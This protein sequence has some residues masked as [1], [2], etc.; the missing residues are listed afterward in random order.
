MVQVVNQDGVDLG[1]FAYEFDRNIAA[2]AFAACLKLWPDEIDVTEQSP[3]LHK[4][5]YNIPQLSRIEDEIDIQIE[6]ITDNIANIYD[7]KYS[8][9]QYM[10]IMNYVIFKILFR[11]AIDNKAVH[12]KKIKFADAEKEFLKDHI[13]WKHQK[14]PE[15]N[16]DTVITIEW[17]TGRIIS[18]ENS[19]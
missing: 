17:Q 19:D 16:D 5:S 15:V 4:G 11:Q 7:N 6:N 2:G 1:N 10:S 3:A 13:G 8:T 18:I 9:F 12:P 14:P